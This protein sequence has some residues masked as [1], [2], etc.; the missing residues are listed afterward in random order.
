[1]TAL[2]IVLP[3]VALAIGLAALAGIRGR[4]LI[5]T[6]TSL[7][8]GAAGTVRQSIPN[9]RLP[10]AGIAPPP[11]VSLITQ[12]NA[13]LGEFNPASRWLIISDSYAA[14][15]KTEEASVLLQSAA[16]LH[17]RDYALWLALGNALTDH[18]RRLTPAAS[19]AFRRSAAL[20]PTSPTPGYFLGQAMRQ[21]GDRD[22][23]LR[24]WR[25]VLAAAP[26]NASWRPIVEDDIANVDAVQRR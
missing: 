9:E 11:P 5:L 4:S 8:V 7:L 21:S 16:R 14:R 12:R 20:A 22:G 23:A 3:L 18:A 19:L 17:P 10:S 25:G 1:M 13:F 15:G 6:L 2:L 26:A 24:Q